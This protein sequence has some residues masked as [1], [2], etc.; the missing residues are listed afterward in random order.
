VHA[1]RRKNIG[2]RNPEVS[3]SKPR[4]EHELFPQACRSSKQ[5]KMVNEIQ[6]QGQEIKK[7]EGIKQVA[8]DF[9]KDLYSAPCEAP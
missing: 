2:A 8:H 4:Q 1:E 6:S 9:F 5:F 7:F 3:G